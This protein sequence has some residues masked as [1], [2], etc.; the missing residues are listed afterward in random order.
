MRPSSSRLINN[1]ANTYKVT[2][3]ASPELG[4]HVLLKFLNRSGYELGSTVVSL[5]H[6]LHT[7][8]EEVHATIY[9]N[10][11]VGLTLNW[12]LL[13][14]GSFGDIMLPSWMVV[15]YVAALRC[16]ECYFAFSYVC[17]CSLH[18]LDFFRLFVFHTL[19]RNFIGRSAKRH[20][21]GKIF[22]QIPA[23][24]HIQPYQIT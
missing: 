19:D 5:S 17:C 21:L 4:A 9:S 7:S 22:S 24:P 3:C 10:V 13:T 14:S 15:H 11:S 2:G 8:T 12:N 1:A 23:F 6:L 16:Y 20:H 18:S